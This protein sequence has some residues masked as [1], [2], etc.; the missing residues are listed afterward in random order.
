MLRNLLRSLTM[1]GKAVKPRKTSLFS[2][3]MLGVETLEDRCVPT[4]SIAEFPTTAGTTPWAVTTGP[5]GNVWFTEKTGSI[6]MINPSTH[7]VSE[8]PITTPSGTPSGITAG[9]DGNLWFTEPGANQIGMINPTTHTVT[10]FAVPTSGSS[11]TGIVAGPDGNLWF[12]ENTGGRVG[13]INPTTHAF[14]EFQLP[15]GG[16]ALGIAAGADGSIWFTENAGNKIG[17]I[18]PI[19]HAISEIAIP[20]S[21]AQANGITAGADGNIWFVEQNAN[22]IGQVNVSTHAITEFAIPAS[23]H[24]FGIT[25][26]ADGNLWFTETGAN[27]IGSFNPTSHAFSMINIP[28]PNSS[29]A[30]IGNGPGGTVWFAESNIHG[31][32]EVVNSP[33]ITAPPANQNVAEG[34]TATFTATAVGFPTPTV[35]WQVSTDNGAT[36]TLLTNGGVYSGVNSATLGATGVTTTLTITGATLDMNGYLYEAVFTNGISPTPS[37]PTPPAKLS[38]HNVLSVMPGLPAEG[39]IN[40]P[41]SQ[42][43]SIVGSTSAYTLF[44]VN[45]FNAGGT[46]L[47]LGDIT[48]NSINGT[49]TISGTPTS[50][51][52]ATFTINVANTAGNSLTQT[53]SIVIKPPLGILTSSLPQAT[54]LAQYHQTIIVVG[55]AGPYTSFAVTNLDPGT[56]GLTPGAITADASTG[57]FVINAMPLGAGIVTFTVSITDALGTTLTKDFTINVNPALAIT[58]SAPQGTAGVDYNQTLTV[59]GGG[60]PYTSLVVTN[61]STGTTGLTPGSFNADVSAGTVTIHGTPLASG[62]IKFTVSVTDAIGATLTKSYTIT[63]NAGLSSTAALPQGTANTKYQQTI[64]VT[65]GTQPYSVFNVDSINTGTTGLTGS[66]ITVNSAT[67]T[68]IVSGTPTAAG[69]LSFTL[70]VT[71]AAGATL[72][73]TYIVTINPP[74]TLTGISA[75][76]WTAGAGGF[77]GVITINGGTSAYT[78]VSSAG[79]PTGTTPTIKGNTLSFI[80]VPTAPKAYNITVTV[81][82]A[83]G[84]LAT[85]TVNVTINAAPTISDLSASQWTVGRGGFNGAMGAAGGTGALSVFSITGVPAGLTLTL[86]GNSIHFVGTPTVVGAFNGTVTLRDAIG[87][88]VTKTFTITINAQPT[89]GNITTTQWTAGKTGFTGTLAIN[90]GTTPHLITAQ[91]GLP[92]GLTATIVGT[93][94][95]FTG[96]PTAAGTFN[97]SITIQD[98]AGATVTKT[99][100]IVINPPVIIVTPSVPASSMGRL[101]S[102]KLTATGGTGAVTFKITAGSLPPGYILN[103]NGTIS[104]LSRGIGTFTFTVTATD[105]IGASVTKT[106]TLK[107]G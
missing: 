83:A 79:V 67:R 28:T 77:T 19:T 93:S 48:T 35:Q 49:I 52:T 50:A 39:V 40:T 21:G 96:T 62:V 74:L 63:I 3:A 68:I 86:T 41:Y 101:Y 20:T 10:E 31:I 102:T 78:L 51:G 65:G 98:A 15:N 27:Q 71:D 61:L 42:T 24:P 97:A 37:A 104:G 64:T 18:N 5:D 90:A 72:T 66:A 69:T 70:H 60:T 44:A 23:G 7:A 16:A 91:S 53:I 43:F 85:K 76:Q 57:T 106:Y 14:S 87:A 58:P 84:A 12:T 36:W 82:D 100:T 81:R 29:S 105:S 94:I 17:L 46:G 34:Q 38:V 25:S 45:N 103:A 99:F 2:R 80:G 95:H 56:T 8:F 30:G 73:K 1:R 47:T 55:G 22:K 26:A 6:G 88:K 89:I 107:V 11:P 59:T 32:A 33:T 4:A 13:S 54:A 9:P 92:T 75:L